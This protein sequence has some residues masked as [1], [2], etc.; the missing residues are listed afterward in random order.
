MN[1]NYNLINHWDTI[2]ITLCIVL[3]C[4]Q[5]SDVCVYICA[6]VVTCMSACSNL[7]VC[8]L[9]MLDFMSL[10]IH[11]F[12]C[13]Y[14]S[15][16]T[17]Y[18]YVYVCMCGHMYSDDQFVTWISCPVLAVSIFQFRASNLLQAVSHADI[19]VCVRVL[20]VGHVRPSLNTSHH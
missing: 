18:V 11:L 4:V 17:M 3:I 10:H 9:V 6:Y 12:V 2:I 7:L 16:C 8:K 19:E 14:V 5:Y 15:A 13:V 20:A 1:Y